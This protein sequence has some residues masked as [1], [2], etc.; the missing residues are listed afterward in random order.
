VSAEPQSRPSASALRVGLAGCG[1]V[2]ERFYLPAFA[3]LATESDALRLAAVAD[4]RAEGRERAARGGVRAFS[5]AAEL[6]ESGLV[7]AVVVATPAETHAEVAGLVLRAGL[8]VLV[9][10]PLARTVAEGETLREAAR[11]A[12]ASLMAGFNRR[13]WAPVRTL[14]AAL[15]EADGAPGVP[16][17]ARLVFD[18]DTSAWAPATQLGDAL[19][20]LVS[21]QL[22]LLR[23]L[24]GGEIQSIR[25]TP[26]DAGRA[27][28]S[29]RLEGGVEA[30][31]R[32]S[33]QARYREVVLV[34]RG[35]SRW[36][37]RDGSDRIAPAGG[38]VRA[39][40]DAADRVRRRL[41]RRTPALARSFDLQ[42]LAFA[43]FVRRGVRPEPG[44]EDGLA[45]LRAVE[46]ARRSAAGGG[47][48][49]R[50]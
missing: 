48:E 3:R 15:R 14:A 49:E 23:H 32:A 41:G 19:E 21:H 6:L 20:D 25:A 5:S 42:L 13:H 12:G 1:R 2:A 31:C 28:V 39:A 18:T 4:P 22:D 10:K 17:R 40:L 9:E 43:D 27:S 11:A 35:G 16:F 7:D 29:V 30:E 45:V 33:Q 37:A 24:F 44:I 8:P 36:V 50:P 47:V 26:G 34:R 38:P 46:A